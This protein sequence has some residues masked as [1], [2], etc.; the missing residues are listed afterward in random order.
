MELAEE[1][2]HFVR[3]LITSSQDATRPIY[4]KLSLGTA[5]VRKGGAEDE[6]KNRFL[7][8]VSLWS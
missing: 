6:E 7:L 8:N 4:L 3:Q 5:L 2:P 1:I